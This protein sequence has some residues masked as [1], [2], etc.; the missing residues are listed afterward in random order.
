MRYIN[1]AV[2]E[3][4]YRCMK[5]KEYVDEDVRFAGFPNFVKRLFIPRRLVIFL[6]L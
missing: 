3:S 5:N 1:V 6:E 2:A 4:L